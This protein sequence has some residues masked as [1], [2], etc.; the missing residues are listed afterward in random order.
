MKK[1]II[2][3]QI[4]IVLLSL[5][6]CGTINIRNHSYG[7]LKEMDKANI[8]ILVYDNNIDIKKVNG[9]R[10]NWD[11]TTGDKIIK[12]PEG[13]YKFIINYR[14]LVSVD[15]QRNTY[16]LVRNAEIGPVKLEGGKK[17]R[18][19]YFRMGDKISFAVFPSF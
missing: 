5:N 1:I 6:G 12:I 15:W 3:T 8:S 10:V 16:A 11:M 7:N 19:N 17:Y 14:Q 2:I 4:A 9:K 13:E 18:I